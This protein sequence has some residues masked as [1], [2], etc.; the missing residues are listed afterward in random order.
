MSLN[1]PRFT[2]ERETSRAE[3]LMH[4]NVIGLLQW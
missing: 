3:A 2:P 1:M 4:W